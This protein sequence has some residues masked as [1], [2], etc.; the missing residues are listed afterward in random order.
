M[1]YKKLYRNDCK[2]FL[3]IT[4]KNIAIQ[5]RITCGSTLS[6]TSTSLENRFKTRPSGVISKRAIFQRKTFES[7]DRCISLAA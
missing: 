2:Q 3:L 6:T 7:I 4:E 1:K 5:D